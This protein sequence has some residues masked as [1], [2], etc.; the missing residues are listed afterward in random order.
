MWWGTFFL[1]KLRINPIF[2]LYIKKVHPIPHQAIFSR[3]HHPNGNAIQKQIAPEAR[4]C[5][6]F[7][8]TADSTTDTNGDEQ[9]SCC[10]QFVD[11]SLIG[12]N[13]FWEFYNAPDTTAETLFLCI[14]DIFLRLDCFMERMQGYCFDGAANTSGRINGVQAKLKAEFPESLYIHCSNHALDLILQEAA[15]EGR[16]IA[17][18]LN[19]V[20]GGFVVITQSLKR[21]GL[22]HR[23][24]RELMSFAICWVYV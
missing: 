3:S 17:D 12:Q 23:C 4:N 1:T 24:L 14:K 19:F 15:K 5:N 7:G 22:F 16:L 6:F 8:F 18:T 13:L 21:K 10:L 2:V 9:F 11:S 20:K